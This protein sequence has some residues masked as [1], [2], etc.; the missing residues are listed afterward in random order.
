MDKLMRERGERRF[1]PGLKAGVSTP[2]LWWHATSA[3]A[4]CVL[5]LPRCPGPGAH[6]VT[7]A[8]ASPTRDGDL[9]LG[10]E[11]GIGTTGQYPRQDL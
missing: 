10:W 2:Q 4:E 1:L 11:S 6:P 5:L 9:A 7:P 3:A 8:S